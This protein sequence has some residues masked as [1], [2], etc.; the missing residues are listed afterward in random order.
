MTVEVAGKATAFEIAVQ[1][2]GCRVDTVGNEEHYVT[3]DQKGRAVIGPRTRRGHGWLA[4]GKRSR[5]H[6]QR[7]NDLSEVRQM[8]ALMGA[9]AHFP[10]PPRSRRWRIKTAFIAAF[11]DE[12]FHRGVKLTAASVMWVAVAGL[13][14][15]ACARA[16]VWLVTM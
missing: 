2:N 6:A 3:A 4:F 5:A 7:L 14:L 8:E 10:L 1:H 9:P 12:E 16:A 13:A 11:Y 15:V